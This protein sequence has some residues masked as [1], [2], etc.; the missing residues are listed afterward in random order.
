M[1]TLRKNIICKGCGI[2]INNNKSYEFHKNIC[3]F[4]NVNYNNKINND[5]IKYIISLSNLLLLNNDIVYPIP[6]TYLLNAILERGKIDSYNFDNIKYIYNLL[7]ND[8][9]N[10]YDY[11]NILNIISII[12]NINKD[13]I[14]DINNIYKKCISYIYL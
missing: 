14:I 6:K 13:I 5:N 3:I 2:E 7:K 9:N 4:F 12:T 11:D 10:N 1:E 8:N